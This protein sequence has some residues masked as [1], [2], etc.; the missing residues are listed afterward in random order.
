M[1]S[2][3]GRNLRITI[4]GEAK[5]PAI[6]ITCDGLP[7]GLAV[8]PAAM[9]KALVKRRAYGDWSEEIRAEDT[10][11]ILSGVTAG[12]T[13]GAPL[14]IILN[15]NGGSL[16]EGQSDPVFRP[17][18]ADYTAWTKLGGHHDT[19][20][21]GHFSGRL[22]AAMVA[23]GAILREALAGSGVLIGSHIAQCGDVRDEDFPECGG[24][25][26]REQLESLE[27]MTFAV[28]DAEKAEEMREIIDGV[29][30]E[31]D[32]VGGTLETAVI[33]IPTGVGAPFFDSLEG[34]LAHLLFAVPG[35]KGVEF[36]MGFGFAY[37]NGS[38]ANDQWV[39]DEGTV[40]T[41]SN[42]SGGINGG[43]S[44]GMPV[45]FRTV[46]RPTPSI[47][48]KQQT[49]DPVTHEEK[50]LALTGHFDPAIFHRA[51]VVVD[52]VTAIGLFDLM[53][54]RRK[55]LWQGSL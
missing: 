20:S 10:P 43:I 48:A 17:S 42:M 44:N 13:N 8:D 46:F 51:R 29:Q 14:T 34:V 6:G 4:F 11:V 26:L 50:E 16:A 3:F 47:A 41:K 28:I 45:I 37:L 7:A 2:T 23:L 36:G 21:G 38:E 22:T 39:N 52:S 19:R 25:E 31:G 53:L 49:V 9:E 54:E 1:T 27:N 35:V 18:H 15:N 12:V 55:D 33:G 32:S 24:E 40:A 30:A 5:G